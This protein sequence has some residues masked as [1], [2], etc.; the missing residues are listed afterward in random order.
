VV[1]LIIMFPDKV[2]YNPKHPGGFGS[3][4]KL[5]KASNNKKRCVEE[6]LSCQ[7][8]YTLHKP[9]RKN[10]P[11]NPYTVTNIDDV[12]DMDLADLRS[13]YKYNNK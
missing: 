12:W 1:E 9:V 10:F 8:K 3:V 6:W 5:V 11:L 7:S 2:H 4:A 13:L